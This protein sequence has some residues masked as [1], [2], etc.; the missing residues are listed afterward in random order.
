MSIPSSSVVIRR[1]LRTA[2]QGD[3]SVLDAVRVGEGD[4]APGLRH[5]QFVPDTRILGGNG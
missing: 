5:R 1:K 2:G 3:V 4:K